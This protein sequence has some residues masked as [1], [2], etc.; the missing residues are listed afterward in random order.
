M[1]DHIFDVLSHELYQS[2]LRIHSISFPILDATNT[3][4]LVR[5]MA[6]PDLSITTEA[7]HVINV[8]NREEA[9]SEIMAVAD[10]GDNVLVQRYICHHMARS[11]SADPGL[12]ID[13]LSLLEMNAPQPDFIIYVDPHD[14]AA[15][16]VQSC[17][18]LVLQSMVLIG[19]TVVRIDG[20][21]SVHQQITDAVA[22]VHWM[23]GQA[24]GDEVLTFNCRRF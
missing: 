7:R 1:L 20:T 15:Q 13:K 22:S 6:Q 16:N 18:E 8:K 9:R 4:K 21:K 17:Y 19:T 23:N 14:S 3:G 12:D 2:Q 5:L 10:L 24:R 11:I